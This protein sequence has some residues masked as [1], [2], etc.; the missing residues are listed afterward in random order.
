MHLI[1]K[2]ILMH[3]ICIKLGF[4]VMCKNQAGK[5]FIYEPIENII[6]IK[7]KEIRARKEK[8]AL[9]TTFLKEDDKTK[10]GVILDLQALSFPGIPIRNRKEQR[11]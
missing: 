10:Q 6:P 9:I 8:I 7:T 11:K 3:L 1:L 5:V 4:L 2:C